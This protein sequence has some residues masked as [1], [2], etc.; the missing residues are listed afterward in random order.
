MRVGL[1]RCITWVAA[2]LAVPTSG[3]WADDTPSP[4]VAPLIPRSLLF[5]NPDRV[6]PQIS[7]DGTQ[8]AWIAPDAGVLNVWVAPMDNLSSARAVTQDRKRG[9][10]NYFWAFTNEHIIYTQDR[11]GDEN[12][13]AYC[14]DLKSGKTT[15]L[16]PIDGVQARIEAVSDRFPDEIL[17]AIND[18]DKK[19][20]DIHRVNIRTAARRLVR[21]NDDGY[22][23]FVTDSSYVVRMGEKM[24]PDGGKEI[25]KFGPDGNAAPF[26]TV[27]M[28]DALTTG[29]GGFDRDAKTMYMIDSRNRDTA[30]LVA[31]DVATGKVTVL[32]ENA[33]ADAGGML[34]DPV[35]EKVQ[36]VA[37]NYDRRQW[38]VIDPG[39]DGDLTY[40][41]S[42]AD[43]DI[44]VTSR[45]RDDKRWVVAFIMDDGPT[46]YYLYERPARK[47]RFLF[48][49]RPEL[50]KVA[51]AKMRPVI[52][53]SRD[54][55][56]LVSYLTLPRTSDPKNTG[57][58]DRPLPMVLNVHGGP[59]AR[60]GWGL[61]PTHQWLAN[62]GFA[63]LSVNYR[64][65]TGFGKKFIN[66]A[67]FEWA[68]KM[69]DDLLDAVDWAVQEKIA[70][71]K[72]V[73]I[74]GG[75][76]GGYATL[77]GLTFTPEK[78]ACGVDIVGPSNL[79]T[80]LNSIPPYWE[81]M[82]DMFTKRV[83]DHRTEEGRKLLNERSPLTR[84]DQIKRPLL[85]GQGANDPRVKQAESDQ[86]VQAMKHR[87][88]P[89]TYVLYPDEGHGFARPENRM[90][91]YAVAEAFLSQQLGT[92]C[93]PLGDDLIGSSIQ[94]PQGAEH[95][96][97]LA[98]KAAPPKG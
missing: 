70:D 44:E 94:V 48:S 11:D 96:P 36:A 77:V 19:L 37:F 68:G 67:N 97:G 22:V 26:A 66:A 9:I 89:V 98:V 4:A 78:F 32:A 25:V 90:S 79:L 7:P 59:W 8:L 15:D 3:A 13:H 47:A 81:P 58:P 21:Q 42:V 12:W 39:V 23:G 29:T 46:R 93:E 2:G 62:R 14:T 91:F 6:A 60:D 54:G 34:I 86:I 74:M 35:T 95:I 41:K 31:H 75:S 52:I 69:H 1:V 83:G 92:R 28:E 43:G 73:A 76:Y 10:R 57:R 61:N 84:V 71:P 72:R 82:V 51:L 18:R 33:K 45:T 24:R 27:A 49:N 20:H 16:T 56:D 63:V 88:I 85:I 5:G 87:N 53:K 17:I 38:K 65:S 64:G 40:L 30:A 80:L 55:L 50:E